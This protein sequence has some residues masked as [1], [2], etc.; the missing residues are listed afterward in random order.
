MRRAV[1]V[2]HFR[3]E[4]RDREGRAV[5][6]LVESASAN[7]VAGQLAGNGITP[8]RILQAADPGAPEADE[9]DLSRL[10]PPPRVNLEELIIFSRQ[11]HSLMRAGIPLNRALK[12][13]VA[14][15]RHSTLRDAL[16]DIATG[17]EGG[18][19]LA[20]VMRRHPRVFN[21]LYLSIIHVG[22]NT[23]QLDASFA[24]IAA[25]LE[26][27]RETI[28]R[29]K[30]ATRYPMFVVTAIA[31][32]I[33]VINLFVIPAF[34]KVFAGFGA[35]LPWQTQLLISLSAFTVAWWPVILAG[36]V[37]GVFGFRRYVETDAGRYQW[38]RYKLRLPLV[39]GIFERITMGRFART[40]AMMTAA[41]VPIIQT[42]KVVSGAVG[43][44]YVGAKV[45][46]IGS[47]IERG[48]SLVRAAAATKM[49]S[50]LVMQMLAVGEETGQVD[51]LL[52]QVAEFYEQ[53]VD[54]DL[55]QLAD[56]IEPIMI[57]FVGVLVLILALGVFLPLWDLAGVAT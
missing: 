28:K 23:G 33:G 3:Y 17:I 9:I 21:R 44:E 49:F 51:E 55:K 32:A 43:N 39:G 45:R 57:I 20:G 30:S 46:D 1:S 7:A 34:A 12:G 35:A 48:E 27:E 47:S 38:D 36:I 15:V 24:Q 41:G 11:M 31:V 52:V 56:A 13:M 50:P 10:L 14:S 22:E 18:G 40:F 29:M 42:L 2:A 5:D 25:Y 4:G 6:G 53:E 26:L 37:V 16:K 19:D 54:Y 8:V